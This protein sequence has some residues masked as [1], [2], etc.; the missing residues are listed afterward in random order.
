MTIAY[1]ANGVH[2]FRER[3]SAVVP[4]PLPSS[5]GGPE[6]QAAVQAPVGTTGKAG[7]ESAGPPTNT[8]DGAGDGAGGS[9]QGSALSAWPEGTEMT[10][11]AALKSGPTAQHGAPLVVEDAH[12]SAAL[13]RGRAAAEGGTT[14]PPLAEGR[15]TEDEM[16]ENT[17]HQPLNP[18]SWG[19]PPAL[20]SLLEGLLTREVSTR[21]GSVGGATA[22]RSHSLFA[23]LQ[24]ELLREARLPAPWLPNPD[25]VYAKDVVPPLSED[26]AREGVRDGAVAVKAAPLPPT[27]GAATAVAQ[28]EEFLSRWDF[29]SA[30]AHADE[31]RDLVRKCPDNDVVWEHAWR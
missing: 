10:T 13:S 22:V 2:P 1:A 29:V 25:L 24:W 20:T 30:E 27:P 26:D 17:L 28:P 3:Q 31:L 4:P 7:A 5:H 16:N 14:A 11:P 8:G 18:S 6:P 12:G 9:G 21:L 19:L 15:L 23:G